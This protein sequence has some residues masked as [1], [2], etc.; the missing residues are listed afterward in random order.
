[1]GRKNAYLKFLRLER[2]L[3]R[4]STKFQDRE[5]KTTTEKLE[6][7][8]ARNKYQTPSTSTVHPEQTLSRSVLIFL[9]TKLHQII[10]FN[11]T[12]RNSAQEIKLPHLEM[13]TRMSKDNTKSMRGWIEGS[14]NI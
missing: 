12:L 13:I 5:K 14:S 11:N 10:R 9:T 4:R 3:A 7:N 1:V 6:A 8:N 2:G